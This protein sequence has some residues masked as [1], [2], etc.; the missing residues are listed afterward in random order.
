MASHLPVNRRMLGTNMG[1]QNDGKWQ[2]M[3]LLRWVN[4]ENKNYGNTF[5]KKRDNHHQYSR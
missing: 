4:L 3:G 2:T 1:G 5:E